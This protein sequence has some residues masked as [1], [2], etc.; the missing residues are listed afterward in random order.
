MASTSALGPAAA[1][2]LGVLQG[3]APLLAVV[4]VDRIVD[5]IPPRPVFPYVLVEADLELPVNT[6]GPPTALKFGSDV[7]VGV[8]I[9]SQY[10][11]DSEA[12]SILNVCKAALDCQPVTVAG[13]VG[14]R[15]EFESATMVKGTISGVVTRELVA[16]FSV[17]GSQ[18]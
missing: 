16:T 17:L 8:R 9:V 10:R 2:I 11:G 3:H 13:Y 1:A 18:G 12:T 7:K 4:P 14:T 5:E 6:M 15:A